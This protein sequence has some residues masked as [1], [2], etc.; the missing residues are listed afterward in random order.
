[1]GAKQHSAL[2]EY[3]LDIVCENLPVVRRAISEYG[4]VSLSEYVRNLLLKKAEAAYQDRDDLLEVV[5]KYAASLLGESVGKKIADDL[6]VSPV[7]LT[8]NHHGVDYFSQSVQGSL[9]FAL[10][11]LS[12]Q[13]TLKQFRYLPAAMFLST[14]RHIRVGC[15]FIIPMATTWR[16]CLKNYRYSLKSS[17]DRWSVLYLLMIRLWFRELNHDSISIL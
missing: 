3:F 2:A 7:V 6:A 9:I 10:N 8:A 13:P 11:T 12:G 14:M 5:Q 17:A 15:S 4:N 16:L 1:M